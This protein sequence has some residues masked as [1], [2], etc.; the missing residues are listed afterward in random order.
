MTAVGLLG[1]LMGGAVLAADS[2]DR[3]VPEEFATFEYL[4]GAWKGAGIPTANRLRGWTEKHMWAWK[5]TNGHPVG[6]TME[7][8]GDKTLSKGRLSFDAVK[9][10]YVLN[11]ADPDGKPVTFLGGFDKTGKMLVL[12]R[13]GKAGEPKE[14][15]TLFPNASKI[16]YTLSLARKEAGSPQYKK[17]TEV[18]VTKEGE[19]FAAGGGAADL[20]KCILTGGAATMT[21]SYQG[22]SFP[23]CCTGC[24]DEFLENPEKYVKKAALRAEKGDS[25]K[26]AKPTSRAKDDDAFDGLV[27]EP[28]KK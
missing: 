21:V 13:Q 26:A 7:F 5:F 11:G 10:Q 6:L 8:E 2:A 17:V 18:G 1:V 25:K 4:V 23:I 14:Q 28:K 24:R 15:L 27:D 20:P 16:R 3:E 22:K 12:D 9:K 19:S